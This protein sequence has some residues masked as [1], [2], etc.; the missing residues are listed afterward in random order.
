MDV[1]LEWLTRV[2]IPTTFT[3][4]V[5]EENQIGIFFMGDVS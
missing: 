3:L 2:Y 1:G 4:S 5:W